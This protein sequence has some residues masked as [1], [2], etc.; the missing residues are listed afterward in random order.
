MGR[1]LLATDYSHQS[2]NDIKNDLK[3]WIK[4]I[5]K[6]RIVCQNYIKE[7]KE[8]WENREYDDFVLSAK[9][10]KKLLDTAKEDLEFVLSEIE[11]EVKE[12]HINILK[13]L[14]CNG[15]DF[16]I[17]IGQAK[18]NRYLEDGPE[19]FLYCK[20]R[21]AM[22][23]LI[24]LEELAIRLGDFIGKKKK[25]TNWSALIA[26]LISLGAFGISILA[27]LKK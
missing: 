16:N 7:L 6:E 23:N 26:N 22:I 24:D 2:F 9:R 14:G 27:Y 10:C 1:S 8:F 15:A 21:D 4:H 5:E 17:E 3:L 12:N 11:E 19:Y 20:L 25:H 18:N 13:R